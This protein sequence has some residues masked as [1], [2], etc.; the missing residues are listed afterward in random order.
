M[1]PDD[2]PIETTEDIYNFFASAF[3]LKKDLLIGIEHERNIYDLRGEK[4]LKVTHDFIKNLM[5]DFENFGW[6][7]IESR[8]GASIPDLMKN[9][10]M[11]SIDIGGGIEYSGKPCKTFQ[12]IIWRLFE[13]I[14]FVKE[15][16]PEGY[17]L[18]SLAFDTVTK[19]E[20]IEP[21]PYLRGSVIDPYFAKIMCQMTSLQINLDYN[22]QEDFEKKM[23]VVF[24]FQPLICSFFY[25]S[26]IDNNGDTGFAGYRNELRK[27]FYDRV[28]I[29]LNQ[30]K[31]FSLTGFIENMI[32]KP[33]PYVH[34]DQGYV[35]GNGQTFFDFM[36]G[37]LD[38]MPKKLP[39]IADL[40]I[41][42]KAMPHDVRLKN[43]I[44]LRG[45]DNM[46]LSFIPIFIAIWKGIFYSNEALNDAFSL[47]ST[48]SWDKLRDWRKTLPKKG[49][50]DDFSKK[51]FYDIISIAKNGLVSQGDDT[52]YLSFAED[53]L[54]SN[55]FLYDDV[56]RSY[57]QLNDRDFI[58][59]WSY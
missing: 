54:M 49:M 38:L 31:D 36:S 58:R 52:Y 11:L 12:E 34:T 41:L 37:K 25:T 23:N 2:Q 48:I 17:I 45:C 1:I 32:H 16:L 40:R 5:K 29:L 30:E 51:I 57:Q 6:E 14:V 24:K 3:D 8:T 53:M 42:L 18:S 56:R 15:R 46:P 55:R 47:S 26:C 35:K 44:E 27:S 39:T 59:K 9:D 21:I 19:D 4:P 43:Y 20:D 13:N 28:N 10:E 7:E 22:S 50:G 33:L